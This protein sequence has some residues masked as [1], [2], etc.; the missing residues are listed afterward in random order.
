MDSCQTRCG[1]CDHGDCEVEP[2]L[3]RVAEASQ[4]LV[5]H[6]AVYGQDCLDGSK[7]SLSR[8]PDHER[9]FFNPLDNAF[10]DLCTAVIRMNGRLA[11][12]L[13][14]LPAAP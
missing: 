4:R 8:V 7:L 11:E 10:S 9:L 6:A 14:K 5:A 12:V 2:L 1:P 13:G 3:W